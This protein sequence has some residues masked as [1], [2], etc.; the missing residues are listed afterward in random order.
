MGI[1][2]IWMSMPHII[3][4]APKARRESK[5]P[6]GLKLQTVGNHWVGTENRT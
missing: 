3:P 1:L 4:G 6:E 2:P 5:T